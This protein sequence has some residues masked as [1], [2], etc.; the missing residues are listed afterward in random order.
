MVVPA[1]TNATINPYGLPVTMEDGLTTMTGLRGIQDARSIESRFKGL[2]LD[3]Q[4]LVCICVIV[5]AIRGFQR[6]KDSLAQAGSIAFVRLS[7]KVAKKAAWAAT[8]KLV[9]TITYSFEPAVY[10]KSAGTFGS[11]PSLDADN[12]TAR[13]LTLT[14]PRRIAAVFASWSVPSTKGAARAVAPRGPGVIESSYYRRYCVRP[15]ERCSCEE[16]Y[17][18]RDRQAGCHHHLLLRACCL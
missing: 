14:L 5:I 1:N 2:E 6:H 18:G 9:A 13:N 16:G 10:S 3:I 11:A 15:S 4:F 8:D 12:G 7:G 17:L